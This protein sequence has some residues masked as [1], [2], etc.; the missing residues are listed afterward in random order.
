MPQYL[1]TVSMEYRRRRIGTRLAGSVLVF[2]LLVTLALSAFQLWQSRKAEELRL[3]QLLAQMV[4]GAE[5]EMAEVAWEEDRPRAMM[6]AQ[7]IINSTEVAYVSVRSN[8]ELLTQTGE[9]STDVLVQ[10]VALDSR[11]GEKTPV[12]F[13]EFSLGVDLKVGNDKVQSQFFGILLRTTGII[14]LSTGLLL[15]LVQLMVTRHLRQIGQFFASLSADNISQELVLQRG[16][17]PL[18]G[19]DEF[20][21]LVRG[22]GQMQVTLASDLG[23]RQMAENETIRL[24]EALEKRVEE[25]TAALKKSLDDLVTAQGQLIQSEKMASL[26]QLVANV[27]HEINTPIGAV[28]ASGVNITSALADTLSAMPTLFKE[29]DAEGQYLFQNLIGRAQQSRGVLPTRQERALTREVTRKLEEEGISDAAHKAAI[30]V[31]LNAHPVLGD[32]LPLLRHPECKVILD[33]A[34]G[35]GD[36]VSNAQNINI[37]VQQVSKIVFVLKSYAR[38][39]A[40]HRPVETQLREGLETVLTIYQGQ[41]KKGVELICHFEPIAPLICLADELNQ[42][43]TN[44]IHNAIQAMN[45]QG[46][47]TVGLSRIADEAVVS[48][49]DTGGGIPEHIRGKIFDAFFTTKP[50]G[51]GSGLGLDIV[52]KIVEKHH[53]RIEVQSEVGVGT[54]FRVVLPYTQPLGLPQ[55]E[56]A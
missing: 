33:T 15:L 8:N 6:I 19:G 54:T 49:G 16:P 3:K 38:M 48:F 11:L 1:K 56:A 21:V 12:P 43:W 17:T 37:A 10:T 24:N 36:I 47:L 40:F 7:S 13:G 31:Q 5:R 18:Q 9:L 25:R 29:L 4:L 42:V 52:K 41:L 46:V 14:F 23:R 2:A 27:A 39:G 26:G 28:K 22:V 45:N 20:D 55:A 44:L 32:L 30:L 50:V 51:E 53:G 35:I 34:H